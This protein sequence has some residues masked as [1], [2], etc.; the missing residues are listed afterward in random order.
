LV[1]FSLIPKS[2]LKV[3][4]GLPDGRGNSVGVLPTGRTRRTTRVGLMM[5]SWSL[6]K[7]QERPLSAPCGRPARELQGA[8]PAVLRDPRLRVPPG[9]ARRYQ[10]L[11]E[12]QG[13]FN[14]S[15]VRSPRTRETAGRASPPRAPG[16]RLVK[17]PAMVFD[18]LPVLCRGAEVE[19]GARSSYTGEQSPA[20]PPQVTFLPTSIEPP[21]GDWFGVTSHRHLA[22]RPCCSGGGAESCHH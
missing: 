5:G 8:R 18:S 20:R 19:A 9:G 2:A 21:D 22:Q 14:R 7:P 10:D 1:D 6:L 4:A 15:A 13:T 3:R 12:R 11:T 16:D 17:R